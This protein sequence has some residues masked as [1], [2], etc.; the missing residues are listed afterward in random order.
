ME[1]YNVAPTQQILAIAK[2]EGLNVL[3]KYHWG[4]VPFWAK[5]TLDTK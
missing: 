2:I 4:L 1:N 5:D 3:D